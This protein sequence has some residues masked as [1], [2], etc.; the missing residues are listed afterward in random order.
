MTRFALGIFVV[1]FL[2]VA[3]TLTVTIGQT[4]ADGLRQVLP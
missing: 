1:L 2:I 4:I 3:L